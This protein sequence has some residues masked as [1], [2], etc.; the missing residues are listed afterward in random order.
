MP[1]VSKKIAAE[2]EKEIKNIGDF[3]EK[4]EAF[5][6][7]SVTDVLEIIFGG[8][9]VLESSD[10]HLEPEK[11]RAK[12]RIRIDGTLQD[13]IFLDKKIYESMLSRIKLLSELK[14]NISDRPQNGRF[15]ILL[16]D[17]LIEIRSSVIPAEFGESVVMRI[18]NPKNLIDME[19]LG[20]RKDLFQTIEREIKKPNGMAIVTGPTGSGKTTTL[21]AF[22]KKIYNPEIKIITIEDPIEYRLEGVSQTR[23]SPEK[24]YD[25]VNGL[26]SIMRQDPDVILVGEIRD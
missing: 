9:I 6:P 4:I 12:L 26:K 21:Y 8:A 11:D 14:F 1:E 13:V 22:L 5:L 20:L 16:K 10:I 18:L 23:V 15:S 3:K 17:T 2:I 25:F 19:A 7:K 24:G